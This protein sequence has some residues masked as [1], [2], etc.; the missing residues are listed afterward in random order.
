MKTRSE[1]KAKEIVLYTQL[2][3][4]IAAAIDALSKFIDVVRHIHI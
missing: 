1:N 3:L 2:F 4:A